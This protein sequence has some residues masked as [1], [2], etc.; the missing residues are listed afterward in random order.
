MMR[1]AKPRRLLVS[2]S[3]FS[4]A[5]TAFA[6]LVSVTLD[7]YRRQSCFEPLHRSESIEQVEATI[8][9]V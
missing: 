5:S 8:G 7:P 2:V 1:A 3:L 4:R 9:Q 6:D